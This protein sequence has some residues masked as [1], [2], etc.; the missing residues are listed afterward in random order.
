LSDT[1]ARA[2][3]SHYEAVGELYRAAWGDSLHFVPFGP[4]QDRQDALA[5]LECRLIDDAGLGRDTSVLDVGCGTG[6]VALAIARRSGARVTGIDLVSRHIERARASATRTGLQE[7]T[8]FLEADATALPFPDASFDHVYAIESAYH[9]ADK[10]LFYGECARVLRPGG[11]FLGTDW[12]RGPSRDHDALLARFGAQFAV[13]ELITPAA[14]RGHLVACGLVPEV[15]VD[16]S[17]LGDVRPNWAALDAGAWPGL[18]RAAR[19]APPDALSTFAAG[20][21][22]LAEAAACGAFV[23]GYWRAS[24]PAS[25]PLTGRGTSVASSRAGSSG[26]PHGTRR[27]AEP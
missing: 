8:T 12:L 16:M 26:S 5:A 23:L 20:V 4:G 7:R 14:L 24:K 1:A 22:T 6:A 3:R 2:V 21:R 18:A 9:A 11:R 25:P 17:S 10:P 13:P 15:V 27:S 19:D